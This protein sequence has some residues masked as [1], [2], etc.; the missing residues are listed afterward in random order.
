MAVIGLCVLHGFSLFVIVDRGAENFEH[1][2]NALG[3]VGNRLALVEHDE[4]T[5]V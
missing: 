5:I 1:P 2:V 3:V 4:R